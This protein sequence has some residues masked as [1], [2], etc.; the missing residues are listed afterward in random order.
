MIVSD[1]Y[2]RFRKLR[3]G[4]GIPC[5][6]RFWHPLKIFDY[7]ESADIVLIP[8]SRDAFSIVKSANRTA[9]CLAAGKAVVADSVPSLEPLQK[10]IA[11]DDWKEGIGR[12]LQKDTSD[13]V[14]MRQAKTLNQKRYSV[15]AIA[16]QWNDLL[17]SII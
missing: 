13:D 6:F 9:M 11:L 4:L 8:N 1:D 16:N 10:Y 3:S 2:K 14:L 12:F 5:F 17:R 7:L 15:Q